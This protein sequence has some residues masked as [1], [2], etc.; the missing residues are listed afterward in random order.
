MFEFFNETHR[1]VHEELRR[2]NRVVDDLVQD[3]LQPAGM[4][5]LKDILHWFD[6]AAREHHV[7][8]EKHVF[9]ALLAIGD[10]RVTRMT[11]RLLQDHAWID[12]N[13]QALKPLLLA[14]AGGNPRGE[15]VRLQELAHLFTEL[16][17][18]HMGVEESMAY[19]KLRARMTPAAVA[20]AEQE[21]TQRRKVRRDRQAR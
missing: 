13:W 1:R 7:D 6:T 4:A 2:L 12:D 15:P 3:R 19:P 21:M 10:E 11:R 14:V 9:P 16:Y 8:E 20:A 18:E 5:R 17:M